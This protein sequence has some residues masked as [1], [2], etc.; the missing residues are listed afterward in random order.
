M[1]LIDVLTSPEGQRYFLK[2]LNLLAVG[3]MLGRTD[4][5]SPEKAAEIYRRYAVELAEGITGRPVRVLEDEWKRIED[6][7][8]D[9]EVVERL[10]A[11]WGRMA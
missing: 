7:L 4:D 1:R 6:A 10:R 3:E 2:M 11:L 9:P 8:L 5:F